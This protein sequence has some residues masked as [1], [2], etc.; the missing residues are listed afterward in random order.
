M[1]GMLSL[2][3]LMDSITTMTFSGWLLRITLL[4]G[5][6]CLYLVVARRTTPAMRHAVAVGSLFAVVLLPVASRLLPAVPLPIL[7]APAVEAPATP[8]APVADPSSI[9][10]RDIPVAED[11]VTT[12]GAIDPTS[13]GSYAVPSNYEEPTAA[14]SL[15]DRARS[16][17]GDAFRSGENWRRLGL[18]LWWMV[19]AGLLIRLGVAFARCHQLGTRSR[20]I[21]DEAMHVE[22]ERACRVMGLDRMPMVSVS[23]DVR[24]PMVAGLT[25]PRIMLPPSATVWSRERLAIVLLH[26]VAH[27]RRRD[28]VWMLFARVLSASLWFHPFVGLLARH[29]RRE[30]ERA[31]DDLVIASGVRGS[32]YA[33]H[34]VSIA[35]LSARRNPL[36]GATLAFAARSTLEQRVASI[37]SASRRRVSS[38]RM[39]GAVVAMFAAVFVAI[40]AAQPVALTNEEYEADR[41]EYERA[42]QQAQLEAQQTIDQ[43]AQESAYDCPDKQAQQ[44][45][46]EQIA[47]QTRGQ[48]AQQMSQQDV[49]DMVQKQQFEQSIQ[50]AGQAARQVAEQT[51][52]QFNYQFDYNYQYAHNDHDDEHGNEGAEWYDRAT[53]H[54]QKGRYEKAGRAYENAAKFGHNRA[55]AYYNAG[56]SYALANKPDQAMTNLEA[57]FE[58]GFEDLDMYASDED[59]NSLRDTQRFKKLMETA[60]N[61]DEGDQ[62]RR[63]AS[64][65]YD[66]LVKDKDV[67]EGDWS[68]V[69][70]DLMRAGDYDRAVTAFDNEYKL[71]K[72][73]S[74]NAVYNKACARALQGK[75]AEALKLLE[76]SIVTGSV[77]ADHMEDD[78]DLIS[79]HKEKKF[80]Q[81]VDMA[82]D[83]ELNYAGYIGKHWHDDEKSWARSV[84]HFQEMANKYP[85]VGRAWFNLGYAQLKAENPKQATVSFQKSLDMAYKP[86]VMMYNLAC[87]TA[88]SGEIDTAFAWLQKSETAG[89]E[90]W[91][92]ARWD[93]DLDPLR[94]DPRYRELKKRWKEEERKRAEDRGVHVQID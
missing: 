35:R 36:A 38:P 89:F 26:E 30:A 37:L 61:S 81:L 82:R 60:R 72:N 46:L 67:D 18:T 14:A 45:A 94:A 50:Q 92:H 70:V 52:H 79:L 71:S 87:S 11:H 13:V 25:K 42:R 24:V 55:V 84:P 69:G 1:D 20:V 6:A 12:V 32:D 48:A 34:L 68:A 76:Q 15:S 54:Y 63:A 78:S 27:I 7:E 66:R 41:Q 22:V 44:Q 51:V 10:I 57:A 16:F 80:D 31:C 40:S 93:E 39:I 47:Q 9:A 58:E 56:C 2:F 8:H 62:L 19:A 4:S 64:R 49:L 3:T 85:K 90:V 17:L 74:E 91:S 75:K 77:D 23:D 53:N 5:L 28:C 88:L 59:L 21:D 73:T 65:E 29:V 43:L 83:L 86:H 33:E